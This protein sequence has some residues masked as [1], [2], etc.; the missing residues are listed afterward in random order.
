M[1]LRKTERWEGSQIET[2]EPSGMLRTFEIWP[3]AKMSQRC[4]RCGF[5]GKTKDDIKRHTELFHVGGKIMERKK[6]IE[7]ILEKADE[8]KVT[9]LILYRALIRL[10]DAS[11]NT[12]DTEVDEIGKRKD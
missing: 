6:I 3:V 12:L 1:R 9:R 11:L 4:I 2:L 5:K 7:K 10:S 8:K